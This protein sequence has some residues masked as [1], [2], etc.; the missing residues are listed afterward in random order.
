MNNMNDEQIKPNAFAFKAYID[1]QF[2]MCICP[3][4]SGSWS[5]QDIF[6]VENPVKEVYDSLDD[7]LFH[8]IFVVF[9]K[10]QDGGFWIKPPTKSYYLKS[11]TAIAKEMYIKGEFFNTIEKG[12]QLFYEQPPKEQIDGELKDTN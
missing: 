4:I 1:D 7:K 6:Y 12:Y 11:D 8:V 5:E 2:R 9:E 3:R 10:D